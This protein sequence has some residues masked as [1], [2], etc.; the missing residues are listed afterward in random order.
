MNKSQMKAGRM[1]TTRRGPVLF[2]GGGRITAALLTGLRLSGYDGPIVVH[3]R[4]RSKLRELRRQYQVTTEPD[5]HRAV[6][7]AHLLIIAVRPDSVR[8][9]LEELGQMHPV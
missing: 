2:L 8:G 5:L 4:H 9:L 7:Q 3:D 1:R 6:E